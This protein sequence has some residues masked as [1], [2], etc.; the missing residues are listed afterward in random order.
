MRANE[1]DWPFRPVHITY[2]GEVSANK[3]LRKLN[4]IGII[5]NEYVK[6]LQT[7]I[8]ADT[9]RPTLIVE[10]PPDPEAK[11]VHTDSPL[12]AHYGIRPACRMLR[13]NTGCKLCHKCDDIHAL[14]FR[15]QRK[16][17]LKTGINKQ[18][19]DNNFLGELR[20]YEYI[21]NYLSDHE[22]EHSI[23]T[24]DSRMYFKYDCWLL[25]LQELLF[26][27]CFENNVVGVFFTGQVCLDQ[28]MRFIARRQTEF[29]SANL[30]DYIRKQFGKKYSLTQN[31]KE[32]IVHV[33][34]TW[35]RKPKTI[36][37]NQQYE[38]LIKGYSY[39]VE[40]LERVLEEQM[41]LQRNRYVRIRTERRIRKFRENLPRKGYS[42]DMKWNLLWENIRDRFNE[43]CLD[44]AIEYVVV[45]ANK[46]FE[47][48]HPIL[49]KV[50]T[51]T[52][53]LPKAFQE[54]IDADELV[55]NIEKLP[56]EKD[57]LNKGGT[58]FTNEEILDAVEGV[59][60]A[61]SREKNVIRII[62]VPLFPKA[63]LVILIGYYDRNPPRAIENKWSNLSSN[64]P[65]NTF[66]TVVLSALSSVLADSSEDRLRTTLRVLHHEVNNSLQVLYQRM[67]QVLRKIPEETLG[68][69]VV[70][71]GFKNINA[72]LR[73]LEQFT[74]WPRFL[75][76]KY[77]VKLCRVPV[78]SMMYRWRDFYLPEIRAKNLQVKLP[79]ADVSDRKHPKPEADP[80]L[81][82][83][84]TSNLIKNAIK[85]AYDGTVVTL[86]SR[87]S[88]DIGTEGIHKIE[89][90]NYGFEIKEDERA[91]IYKLFF[92]SPK[93]KQ[94]VG[95][96]E[97]Q[98]A[99]LFVVKACI[100]A[101]GW[102][103]ELPESIF[104]SKFCIPILYWLGENKSWSSVTD[105]KVRDEAKSEYDLRKE[106][107]SSICVAGFP[108]KKYNFMIARSLLK[109]T[110]K[111]VFRILIPDTEKK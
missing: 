90:S 12:R 98:G 62:P 39:K 18:L 86:N 27:I 32:R 107:I 28:K 44:F 82:E 99:G 58:S 23:G 42:S 25:G 97:S 68:Y 10:F 81:L 14:L 7:S 64:A 100:D 56:K 48:E 67:P 77:F 22:S 6:G 49:L 59:Q 34:N 96:Y 101:H 104:V 3:D 87:K 93:A 71:L 16:S 94:L 83:S 45:F 37:S 36:F 89:V 8:S 106:E 76:G 69:E 4:G 2:D 50:A 55:F 38:D 33:Y 103:F 51:Y 73:L 21:R 111:N 13:N 85:Y 92:R 15:G 91:A 26:P 63:S 29:L 47:A 84:A 75:T 30:D 105:P 5:S 1:A 9:E 52:D 46:G 95:K 74:I 57:F 108:S 20:E 110:Y 80:D 43:L 72:G 24:I 53:N 61:L 102:P 11:P 65:P 70:K 35:L 109:A 88:F 19:K 66:Y 31:K 41:S 40:G 60:N 79:P 54:S 17:N 78:L